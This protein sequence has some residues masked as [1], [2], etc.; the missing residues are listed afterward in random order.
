MQQ[1]TLTALLVVA[2]VL[3]AGMAL[4]QAIRLVRTGSAS[5]VS[6]TWAGISVAMNVWWLVY[7]LAE[8]L[9]GLVP[10][11]VVAT[12]I[13]V[14]IAATL[15]RVR[16]HRTLVDLGV[17]VALGLAPLPA[18]IVAG[19]GA[20]GVAIGLG[21]GLQLLPAVVASYRTR[22]LDGVAPGTWIMA[23]VESAVWVVYGLVVLDPALLVG[24]TSGVI[25]PT[26]LLLRLD[27]TGHRPFRRPAR[28]TRPAWS[29]G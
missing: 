25:L 29:I 15:V 22:E 13:Y 5:G 8:R 11:S 18:L 14:V 21:Y 16:G 17:G 26:L 6:G 23:W 19:W 9:W 10:V 4:P 12:I 3:G 27:R 28:V 7:G 24:G 20:A 1:L 2:N